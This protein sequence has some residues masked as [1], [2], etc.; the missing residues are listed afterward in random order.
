MNTNFKNSPIIQESSNTSTDKNTGS[1]SKLAHLRYAPVVGSSLS[2]LGDLTGLT[3]KPKYDIP[4][5]ITAQANSLGQVQAPVLGDYL[6]YDPLDTD[7][8]T[9]KLQSQAGATRSAIMD[10]S[11]GNRANA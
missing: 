10:S 6:T 5:S 4:N 2:V 1:N 3:N 7:Y 8:M 9:N 11:G